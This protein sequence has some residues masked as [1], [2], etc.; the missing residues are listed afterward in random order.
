[1]TMLAAISYA[2][3]F[4]IDAFM[5][6][7]ADRLKSGGL[8]IAGVVQRNDASGAAGPAAMWLEDLSSGRRF[9]ISEQRGAAARGCRLDMAGLVAAGGALAASLGEPADLVIVNKFGRQETRGQGLRQ[10]I[11]AVLLAG[12]PLLI[13]VRQD[14][15]SEWREFA[16]EDW[17]ELPAEPV[18]V[19]AWVR[20]ATSRVA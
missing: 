6:D 19:E 1:M 11:A 20:M 17:T 3:G 7:L 18:A 10:E 15:V 5:A 12:L 9:P 16:G 13:A 2:R 8:R 14:I 4:A